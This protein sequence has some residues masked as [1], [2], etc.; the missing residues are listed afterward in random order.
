MISAAWILGVS[1][2]FFIFAALAYIVGTK[3]DQPVAALLPDENGTGEKDGGGTR[4]IVREKVS[5]R[6]SDLLEAIEFVAKEIET[7]DGR[8]ILIIVEDLDKSDLSTAKE[9][10][11]GHATTLLAP[12]VTIVYTFPTALRHDNDWMQVQMNFPNC[13]IL[14]NLKTQSRSGEPDQAGLGCIRSILTKRVEERLFTSDALP[15]LARYSCGIPRELVALARRACL[16]SMKSQKPSIDETAVELAAKAKRMDYQVLLTAE[17]L[18]LLREVHQTR[19]VKNDEAHRA[20]LHN[21]SVLEYR[22][23]GVW[24]DVHPVILPLLNQGS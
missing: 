4:K 18:V 17:Q 10:F 19:Q 8:K 23:D 9:L 20:L 7:N 14:P 13:L 1:F 16:E 15:A 21:L 22:N 3:P 6:I 11:Y 24:Y 12:Q 5:H 2:F